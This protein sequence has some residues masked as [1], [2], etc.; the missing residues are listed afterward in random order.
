LM[1]SLC[2]RALVIDKGRLV[3]QGTIND[4]SNFYTNEIL[5]KTR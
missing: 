3:F 5:N 2:N 4:A 1:K